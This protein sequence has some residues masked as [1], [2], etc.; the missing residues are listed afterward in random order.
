MLS[1]MKIGTKLIF[2]FAIITVLILVIGIGTLKSISSIRSAN[3]ILE[4]E[5]LGLDVANE[6][7]KES[8]KES[9][10]E[11]DT[12][13][14]SVIENYFR[15]LDEQTSTVWTGIAVAVG[16][17]AFFSVVISLVLSRSITS[18]L[19][20]L[21]QMMKMV[22]H[23][24]NLSVEFA[25]SLF[26]RR[27][28][29]GM[30][31]EGLKAM[32]DEFKKIENLAK[33]LAAGNWRINVH[34]RSEQDVMNLNLIMMLEQVNTALSSTAK[35]I[36]KVS[37]GASEMDAASDSLSNG[38]TESAASI[39]QITASMNEVGS[40]TATN[41]QNASKASKL[42]KEAY[43]SANGGQELMHK[44]IEAME[45]ITKNSRDVQKIVKVIDDISFQTNLLAL[46]AAVEAARAGSHGKGF[47]VVAE[48]VRNLA[49][50]SAKAAAETTQMIENNSKQIASGAGIASQTAEMLS[51]IVNQVTQVSTLVDDIARA[52]GEQAQGFSQITHGMQQ[53]DVVT[54]QNTANAE[55]TASVS[56]EMKSQAVELQ[57]LIS[58][59]QLRSSDLGAH[60]EISSHEIHGTSSP[61]S[62][63]SSFHSKESGNQSTPQIS[64]SN[65]IHSQKPSEST[66][67]SVSTMKSIPGTTK[68]VTA[69]T[70]P[71]TTAAKPVTATVKP[72]TTAAKPVTAAVKPVTAAAKPV[73]AKSSSEVKI[74]LSNNPLSGPKSM[75]MTSPTDSVADKDWGGGGNS[76]MNDIH[77]DL[78]DKN[79]GKY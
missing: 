20:T 48:E 9:T 38:S 76:A 55:E 66:S 78:D 63:N 30:I 46:N 47:A 23:D 71:V 69:T 61:V 34:A 73:T 60:S 24:G 74:D 68:P 53:I 6:S 27:D 42:A 26:Q 5:V 33:E 62:L 4:R 35:A 29:V 22:S 64:L 2:G 58:C 15:Q 17:A 7:T 32:V 49:S 11:S 51:G 14:K 25:P 1:S 50:R 21:V 3:T 52:S 57:R 16:L 65:P 36:I 40:Q 77:I 79:F 70:K 28:E 67:F 19:S 37:T 12:S 45:S 18:G 8:T 59:F 72:V 44:M 54:Q 10:N 41:A 75:G 56:S 31:A 43:S 13:K 39:E